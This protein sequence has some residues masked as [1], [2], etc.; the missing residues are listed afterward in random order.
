MS[1][2]TILGLDRL[3]AIHVNDSKHGLGSCK[4]RHE[5]IGQGEMGLEPFRMLLNEPKLA[6]IPMALEPPKDK[7]GKWDRQNLDVLYG[8]MKAEKRIG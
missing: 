5:H 6:G 3:Q 8:L 2:C 7:N 4:D 1:P